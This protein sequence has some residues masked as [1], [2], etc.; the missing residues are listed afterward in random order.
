MQA[1]EGESVAARRFFTL[2]CYGYTLSMV[3]KASSSSSL[4]SY[5]CRLSHAW[6]VK[7]DVKLDDVLISWKLE[8]PGVSYVKSGKLECPGEFGCRC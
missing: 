1:R 8:C 3:L 7:C 5:I 2:T 4:G 6:I